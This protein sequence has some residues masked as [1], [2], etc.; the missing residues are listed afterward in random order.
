VGSWWVV[1]GA[2]R[3]AGHVDESGPRLVS[4]LAMFRLEERHR[5]ARLL[6]QF[7][8]RSNIAA[9]YTT[10][11]KSI[12]AP[13]RYSGVPVLHANG[14]TLTPLAHEGT[15]NM[16]RGR[17]HRADAIGCLGSGEK[18]IGDVR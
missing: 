10:K 13:R 15:N 2:K 14:P 5:A 1:D 7:S 9:V 12:V 8:K 17:Q 6:G 18:W 16:R 4:C 11:R 3:A